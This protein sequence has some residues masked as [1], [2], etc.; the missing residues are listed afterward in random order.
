MKFD[1]DLRLRVL[2]MKI[3]MVKNNNIK[4][5]LL[6]MVSKQPMIIECFN[7]KD[8]NKVKRKKLK[9]SVVKYVPRIH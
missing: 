8:V 3:G 1:A 2:K 9:K 4:N 7:S 6:M 5:I